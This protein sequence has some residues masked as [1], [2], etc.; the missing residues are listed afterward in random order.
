MVA[1][2]AL[3]PEAIQV[4]AARCPPVGL[5][6]VEVGRAG[7]AHLE[8]DGVPPRPAPVLL[9][10]VVEQVHQQRRPAHPG[11]RLQPGDAAL[12]RHGTAVA[13][14]ADFQ[15]GIQSGAR[16]LAGVPLAPDVI[17]GREHPEIAQHRQPRRHAADRHADPPP[18]GIDRHRL[19]QWPGRHDAGTGARDGVAQGR[20]IEGRSHRNGL[21]RGRQD[22]A[23]D[24]D[25]PQ[26]DPPRR[27][28]GAGA[29]SR[30]AP[31]Q[32][33]GHS[34]STQWV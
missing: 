12:G 20:A 16:D 8:D 29:A 34:R 24:P 6:T 10:R 7:L 26:A 30:P 25:L 18:M 28:Q 1:G 14:R 11:R 33:A 31:A 5:M 4:R 27:P 22:G 23:H 19:V 2:H 3:A 32:R 17:P 13:L 15:R 21:I 9:H